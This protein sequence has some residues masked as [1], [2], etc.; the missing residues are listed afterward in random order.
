MITIEKLWKRYIKENGLNIYDDACEYFSQEITNKAK[1]EYDLVEMVIEIMGRLK[2]ETEF[3]KAAKFVETVKANNP[4]FY[5]KEVFLYADKFLITYYSF[6]QEYEKLKETFKFYDNDPLQDY[7]LF[8][9]VFNKLIYT[10]QTE[11]LSHTITKNLDKV[12][13]CDTLI[14]GAEKELQITKG[15]LLGQEI[16]EKFKGAPEQLSIARKKTSKYDLFGEEFDPFFVSPMIGLKEIEKRPRD[17]AFIILNI[18]FNRYMHNKGVPFYLSTEIAILLERYF[19]KANARIKKIEKYSDIDVDS[20]EETITNT[21][22]KF[23]FTDEVKVIV[24]YW[25]SVY[26]YDFLHEHNFISQASHQKNQEAIMELKARAIVEYFP[27]LWKANFVHHWPKPN[28]VSENEFIYENKLF[29]K[30]AEIKNSPFNE[31]KDQLGE[32][33]SQLGALADYIENV[34]EK[35]INTSLLDKIFG[36]KN[37]PMSDTKQKKVNQVIHNGELPFVHE[38]KKVGRNETL[39]LWQ[40]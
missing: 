12:I 27:S 40:W 15:N 19:S 11:L 2:E 13:A 21:T 8:L 14:E 23:L 20:F 3:D 38:T 4:D 9:T 33:I 36:Q 10:Q 39:S 24:A 35:E 30:S 22:N 16:Y 5:K 7:D 31:I 32:E 26:F 34:K 37:M 18:Y 28:F 17:E 25:G 6:K 29:H 1:E